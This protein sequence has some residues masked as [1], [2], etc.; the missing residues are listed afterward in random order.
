M[1][2]ETSATAPKEAR[3]V[4]IRELL[5]PHT[6]ALIFGT[7]AAVGDAVANLLDPLPLKIVLDNVLQ[8][9]RVEESPG[10]DGQ[11]AR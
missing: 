9:A 4:T 8:S 1:T 5:R 3:K 6:K 11:G 2:P 7:L 10:S